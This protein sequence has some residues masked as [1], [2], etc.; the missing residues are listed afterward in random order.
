MNLLKV[1]GSLHVKRY[2][3]GGKI[4]YVYNDFHTK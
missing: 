2:E 3:S 1:N 4:K